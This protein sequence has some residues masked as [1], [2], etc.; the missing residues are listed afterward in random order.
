[1]VVTIKITL[2]LLIVFP[3]IVLISQIPKIVAKDID[4]LPEWYLK[5]TDVL[6][7]AWCTEL[8]ICLVIFVIIIF[9]VPI[10][11]IWKY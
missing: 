9:T 8:V 5:L 11:A 2:T 1:M 6:Y 7:T 4:D 10:M 3:V